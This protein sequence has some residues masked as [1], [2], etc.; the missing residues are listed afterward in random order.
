MLNNK[1]SYPIQLAVIHYLIASI[2]FAFYGV[3]VCPLLEAISPIHLILPIVLAL[4]ARFFMLP[5]VDRQPYEYQARVQGALDFSL[6]FVAGLSLALFNT[7]MY[8]AALESNLKVMAGAVMFGLYIG[9]DLALARSSD[10]A[11]TLI[12]EGRSMRLKPRYASFGKLFAL[13]AAVVVTSISL[14]F[15]LVI[16]KDIHWIFS[17]MGA[18]S[19][20]EA[21]LSILKEVLFIVGVI[22][23]YCFRVIYAYV[24][25]LNMYFDHQNRT[26]NRVK[27]GDL[28]VRVPVI[29]LNEFGH[30]AEGANAMIENLQKSHDELK[31]TRDVSILALASLAETRDNETGAHILRTQY[32]VKALA[33]HLSHHPDFEHELD[34]E[35]IG[36]LSKSAPLHDIGKVGVPDAILLK[37][38]KLTDEEF[39]I[40]KQHPKLGVD[41]LEV[42]ES[43]LGSNSFLRYAREIALCHHEKWDGSGYPNGLKGE[44]IPLSARLMALADVYDALISKRVYKPAFSFEKAKSIILEY[45]GSHFDPRVV[46][47]FRACE[48]EF[49]EIAEKYKDGD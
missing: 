8:D 10:L 12:E 26:L 24:N 38:G 47:A 17:Q 15:I 18:V 35:T 37:P 46:E 29:S 49:I 33:E 45:E 13:S 39:S 42:A 11:N 22:L 36:Q 48:G 6:F 40:M 9:I 34:E 19:P 32:Y 16:N 5:F 43:H 1:K 4:L 28:S 21:R 44:A 41:A 3:Q 31:L 2:L 27:S 30:M 23:A 7:V 25:T 20:A 14:I